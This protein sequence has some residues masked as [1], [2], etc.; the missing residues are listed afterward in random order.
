[1]VL[2]VELPDDIASRLTAAATARGVR[3][4]QMVIEAVEAQLQATE[5][6]QTENPF[7]A[8]TKELQRMAFDGSLRAE[9]DAAVDDPELVV[10]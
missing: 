7:A 5:R 6:D 1:M 2:P 3:P 10:G 9:I 8:I 4:E